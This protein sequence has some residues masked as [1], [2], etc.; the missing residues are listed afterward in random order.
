MSF[1]TTNS[2]SY[3][4]NVP[5][6]RRYDNLTD[7]TYR[8]SFYGELET[9]RSYT[10]DPGE[11][12]PPEPMWKYPKAYPNVYKYSYIQP[13]S[14]KEQ[15]VEQYGYH[16]YPTLAWFSTTDIWWRQ[17]DILQEGLPSASSLTTNWQLPLRLKIKK[18]TVNLGT[19]FAEYAAT[20]SMFDSMAK[21]L[22]TI[23]KF[24]RFK[25][26]ARD[27]KGLRFYG[28]KRVKR[29]KFTT[30]DVSSTWL[31]WN[32]GA[33]PLIGDLHAAY[34]A[35][36]VRALT[37]DIWHKSKVNVRN[38]DTVSI[39]ASNGMTV[40]HNIEVSDFVRLYYKINIGDHINA[41]NPLELAW[42][43]VPFSFVVDWMFN[44]GDILKSLDA[45]RS[46][47]DFTGSRVHK[48]KSESSARGTD[49]DGYTIEQA[50]MRKYNSHERS[51]INLYDD[52]PQSE[53]IPSYK[54]SDS[55]KSL[56]SAVALLHQMR[57]RRGKG[58]RR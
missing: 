14:R 22:W 48:F 51:V 12:R 19:A 29:K 35:Q 54:P 6:W 39:T 45:L 40:E 52:I 10:T 21:K 53:L 30:A 41:G 5:Y 23:Y 37:A 56:T 25:A 31:S 13:V 4:F 55:F 28:Q 46:L 9:S 1:T 58:P 32:F 47:S 15:T 18:R 17:V 57:H 16:P 2:Q 24:A 8:T 38:S 7:N 34:T 50:G 27:I 20:A 11:P 44:L 43:L 3:L 49:F 36:Q 33:G 26:S 42:E